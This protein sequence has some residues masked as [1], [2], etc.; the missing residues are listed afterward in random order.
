MT[1]VMMNN[2]PKKLSVE[3][4]E[5]DE[6]RW[7]RILAVRAEAQKALELARAEKIIGAS[8]EAKVTLFADGELRPL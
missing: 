3:F 4:T 7:E 8:L 2:M 5:A 1:S 6:K